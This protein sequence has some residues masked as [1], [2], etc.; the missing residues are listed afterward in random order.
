[1]D[2][3]N[4]F[5]RLGRRFERQPSKP[6]GA[7]V[8][9]RE[10]LQ[11]AV[12]RGPNDPGRQVASGSFAGKVRYPGSELSFPRPHH[13][14]GR[15]VGPPESATV[16]AGSGL[17]RDHRGGLG[18]AGFNQGDPRLERP[19]AAG[20]DSASGGELL[21]G[22]R[23]PV[24]AHR[25]IGDAPLA[26]TTHGEPRESPASELSAAGP[27]SDQVDRCG[28]L[29]AVRAPQVRRHEIVLARRRRNLD[30]AARP[31]YREAGAAERA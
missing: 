19:N 26:P 18:F 12:R 20:G 29:R 14:A 3:R 7:V 10:H 25:R 27:H 2:W 1:M 30:P 5:E 31:G 22:D 16:R 23:H 8:P 11:A 9:S 28:D 21:R 17:L 24:H 4:W 15:S 13:R 6:T